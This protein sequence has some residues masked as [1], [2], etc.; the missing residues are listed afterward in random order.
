VGFVLHKHYPAVQFI[1]KL[2]WHAY[3]SCVNCFAF[4]S[5]QGDIVNFFPECQIAARGE[6]LWCEFKVKV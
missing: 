2:V 5:S 3:L 4:V 6:T 1:H